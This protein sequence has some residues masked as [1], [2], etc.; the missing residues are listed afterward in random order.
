VLVV[1]NGGTSS[2]P[3]VKCLHLVAIAAITMP[4]SMLV[5]VKGLAT[6]GIVGGQPATLHGLEIVE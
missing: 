5:A 2:P 6:G 3:Y 1:G 4:L